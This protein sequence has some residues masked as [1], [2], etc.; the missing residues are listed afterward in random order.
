MTPRESIASPPASGD[1]SAKTDKRALVT[2]YARGMDGT[3]STPR[4][5]RA[6]DFSMTRTVLAGVLDVV[7]IV[8][9]AAIGRASH[10]ETHPVLESLSVAWPFLAG[11][12]I[13][14]ALA[15]GPIGRS[16]TSLLAGLP[17][18]LATVVIGM[19][20]RAATGRGIAVSFII[21]ATIFLGVFLLGWRAIAQVWH[22]RTTR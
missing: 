20:L 8:V 13:G 21:V 12:A 9:F 4:P 16:A 10:S 22:R 2:A 6:S 11:A 14:W 15:L 19:A 3:T 18:W 5:D 17:I 7:V 1:P